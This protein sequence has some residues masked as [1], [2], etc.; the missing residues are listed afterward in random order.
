[1]ERIVELPPCMD[2]K[3]LCKIAEAFP[4]LENECNALCLEMF[5]MSLDEMVEMINYQTKYDV[6]IVNIF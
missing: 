2:G 6:V 4:I 3:T 1:M 5:D